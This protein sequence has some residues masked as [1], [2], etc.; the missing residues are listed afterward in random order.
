MSTE[1]LDFATICKD[2]ASSGGKCVDCPVGKTIVHESLYGVMCM[3]FANAGVEACPG[4]RNQWQTKIEQKKIYIKTQVRQACS[5]LD[6]LKTAFATQW[7]ACC[8]SMMLAFN[9]EKMI[10][11]M[12]I[13]KIMIWRVGLIQG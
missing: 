8:G 9:G 6:S 7:D 11:A 1:L 4:K 3:W 12:A 2:D 5:S 10:T 13:E